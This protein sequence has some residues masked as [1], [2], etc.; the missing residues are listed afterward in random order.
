MS[1]DGLV[2]LMEKKEKVTIGDKPFELKVMPANK[3]FE[4]IYYLANKKVQLQGI[5]D[6]EKGNMRKAVEASGAEIDEAALFAPTPEFVTNNITDVVIV[7]YILDNFELTD[8]WVL[9]NV[10][11]PVYAKIKEIHD[12]L[13][14]TEEFLKKATAAPTKMV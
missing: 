5:I 11:P 2:F 3:F 7:R 8:E 4:Y 6:K 9:D 13:N 12:R 14:N 10:P 1:K